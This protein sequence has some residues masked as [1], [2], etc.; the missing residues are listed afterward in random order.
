MPP[1]TDRPEGVG[2]ALRLRP[3]IGVAALVLMGLALWSLSSGGANSLFDGAAGVALLIA[4]TLNLYLIRSSRGLVERAGEG[5]SLRAWGGSNGWTARSFDIDR[6]EY[7]T[8]GEAWTE[9][10]RAARAHG[11][12]LAPERGPADDTWHFVRTSDEPS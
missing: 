2:L 6:Y 3:F 9:L 11:Y 4:V 8:E 7:D 1:T 10:V 5:R 12:E